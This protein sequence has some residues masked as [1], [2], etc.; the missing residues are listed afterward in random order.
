MV[1]APAARSRRAVLLGAG[2]LVGAAAALA[3]S[4]TFFVLARDDERD[5]SSAPVWD[6]YY[7]A[8][9]RAHDRQRLAAAALGAGVLLG[10]GALLQWM[11]T[12]PAQPRL[13]A[14]TG[15]QVVGLRGRF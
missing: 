9:S 8:Q 2:L 1:A 7:Q 10:G 5:A 11:L 14:W 4:A 6:D 13:T 15:G 3:G 12:A